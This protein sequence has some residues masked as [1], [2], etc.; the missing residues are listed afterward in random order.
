VDCQRCGHSYTD[1]RPACER[2]RSAEP[3]TCGHFR[4]VDPTPAADSLGYHRPVRRS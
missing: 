4:W 1:H 3:C 2:G